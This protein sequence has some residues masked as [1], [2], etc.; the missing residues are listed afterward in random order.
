MKKILSSL[1]VTMTIGYIHADGQIE[2][3]DDKSGISESEKQFENYHLLSSSNEVKEM[4]RI[5]KERGIAI[6]DISSF[7]WKRGYKQEE[8][9]FGND[10]SPP[11]KKISQYGASIELKSKN[12]GEFIFCREGTSKENG[13]SKL[14]ELQNGLSRDCVHIAEMEHAKQKIDIISGNYSGLSEKFLKD[15]KKSD[16]SVE[17]FI[18]AIIKSGYERRDK[19]GGGGSGVLS[20]P[21]KPKKPKINILECEGRT[22]WACGGREYKEALDRYNSYKS[23]D[24]HIKGYD[25]EFEM[26]CK[27]GSKDCISFKVQNEKDKTFNV[28]EHKEDK[29]K[30]AKRIG[31]SVSNCT[32]TKNSTVRAPKPQIPELPPLPSESNAAVER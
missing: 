26:Y 17:A 8:R 14:S 24:L 25:Y 22:L 10:E 21:T 3:V 19:M 1:I 27:K 15:I 13:V 31:A 12:K 20:T 30:L 29:T 7:L 32:N 4:L 5:F 9:K 18:N 16:P 6:T 11:E 28:L 23:S 2:C